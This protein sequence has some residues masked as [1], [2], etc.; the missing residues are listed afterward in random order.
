MTADE[1]L[2]LTQLL[3]IISP[4]MQE[5]EM[6]NH[7]AD[8]WK[9]AAPEGILR[10]DAIGNLE[11]SYI[12]SHSYPTLALV[13]H[14]DTICVQ[15]TCAAGNGKYKFRS[16]GASPHMLLG[17]MVIVVTEDGKQ[18]DAVVGHD[19]TSQYG[20]PKGL[21]FE[22]LWIDIPNDKDREYVSVGDLAV[23]KPRHTIYDN[24]MISSTS[25]DDRLGLFVIGEVLRKSVMQDIPVNL[26]CV[27]TAQE[28]VG[29]R[30]SACF[31][32]SHIPDATIVLDVDYATDIPTPH[33]DQMG[34]LYLNQGPGI[35]RKADNSRELRRK[36][37]KAA[38][39]SNLP[40]QITLGRF[41]YGGTDSTSLQTARRCAGNHI[42]NISIPCRY[43][44]SPAETAS[45]KDVA[46]A[47]DLIIALTQ[48]L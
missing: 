35:Q 44:H 38:E 21:I 26:V 25:L 30:G 36:I 34:R 29:L 2:R 19:A 48:Q 18:I 41:L 22:D 46:T 5:S 4:S 15:L 1:K 8:S 40:Y 16:I 45:L 11:F 14:A 13:A 33:E 24:E 47:I 23:L 9:S 20:Q 6:M 12:K 39:A 27:A 28:E 10:R 17:Q 42:A 31:E 37:K 32:F 7:L 43:M 3:E